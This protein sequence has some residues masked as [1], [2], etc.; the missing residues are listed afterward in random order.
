MGPKWGL[1]QKHAGPG[2]ADL[3]GRMHDTFTRVPLGTVRL[4]PVVNRP[5]ST[6]SL[7]QRAELNRTY[8]MSLANDHLLQNHYFEAGL[9]HTRGKPEDIHWG[10]ESPT[11]QVR[12]HFL[13]HW[14]IG[15]ASGKEEGP[16]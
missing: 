16:G 9:W 12:G 4:L 5:G 1:P 11:C 8:V 6:P 7:S 2:G 3:G 10:W 14:Q 15:R 13:G